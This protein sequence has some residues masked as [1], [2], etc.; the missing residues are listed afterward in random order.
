MRTVLVTGGTRRLGAA[1]AR[2]LAA[3]GW[4]VIV[5]SHRALANMK[6]LGDVPGIELMKGCDLAREGGAD[7][8]Y[9]KAVSLAGGKLDAV[10][11]NA[12]LFR[13]AAGTLMTVNAVAPRRIMELVRLRGGAVVN[14]LDTHVVS[15]WRR[16]TGRKF[17]VGE[18]E[19]GRYLDS[20]YALLEATV[21]FAEK[22]TPAFRVNAVAPGPV[23]APEQAREK[24]GRLLVARPTPGEV[25]N[26][27]AFLLDT[28]SAT[29][30]IIP[31]D[32]GQH[33]L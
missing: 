14:I 33:L 4:R 13:G 28:P 12:A 15:V 31:V 23:L 20:K 16:N 19:N 30:V 22:S 1:I 29:G 10:V 26:A 32:G 17:P 8:L 2:K 27:V 5:S 25:A 7:E 24:A 3:D 6:E 18:G 21:R 9:W 11:N